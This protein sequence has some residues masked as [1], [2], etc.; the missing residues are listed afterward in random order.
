MTKRNA[1][2]QKYAR[3]YGLRILKGTSSEEVTGLQCR[4]C[5]NVSRSDGSDDAGRKRQRTLCIKVFKVNAKVAQFK[6]HLQEQHSPQWR[7]YEGLLQKNPSEA[8]INAFFHNKATMFRFVER[9][10]AIKYPNID[11]KNRGRYFWGNI[12]PSAKRRRRVRL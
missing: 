2:L 9:G 4:F 8:D 7:V 1:T 3:L 10:R 6:G 12:P 5:T 11:K